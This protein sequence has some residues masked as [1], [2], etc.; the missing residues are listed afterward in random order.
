MHIKTR[1]RAGSPPYSCVGKA[2]CWAD[3]PRIAVSSLIDEYSYFDVRLLQKS[4]RSNFAYVDHIQQM[5]ILNV[6]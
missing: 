3:V 4:P 1:R 5:R 6:C 2:S